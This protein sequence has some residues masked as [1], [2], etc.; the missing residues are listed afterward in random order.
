MTTYNLNVTFQADSLESAK[1]IVEA[2]LACA[3]DD[4]DAS[5]THYDD[6]DPYVES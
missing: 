2:M 4:C 3:S 1:E 5:L 6:D